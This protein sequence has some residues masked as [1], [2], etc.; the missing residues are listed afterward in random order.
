MPNIKSAIKRV[1]VSEKKAVA[2]KNK[3]SALR[4]SLKKAKANIE[5][6][7]NIDATVQGTQKILDQAAAKGHMSKNAASRAKSKLAK[8]ANK[9]KA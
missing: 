6:G 8:A 1:N 5:A 3:K 7:E 2:N 4:T 9:A